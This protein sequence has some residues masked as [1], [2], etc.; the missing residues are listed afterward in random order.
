MCTLPHPGR[1]N[2]MRNSTVK[3]TSISKTFLSI[4]FVLF[5]F[6][7]HTSIGILWTYWRKL[8]LRPKSKLLIQSKDAG[9]S[10]SLP[11]SP[12]LPLATFP[13]VPNLFIS[14]KEAILSH[15]LAFLHL[16][17]PF[18]CSGLWVNVIS[19]GSLSCP[20]IF[21]TGLGVLL[22]GA[23]FSVCFPKHTLFTCVPL[24]Q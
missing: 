18:W 23:A 15:L 19:L 2:C 10:L 8:C 13:L 21:K 12:A 20:L 11:K 22:L 9:H 17:N 6:V 16:M 3:T 1:A 4:G 7:F 14:L 24:C 5:S